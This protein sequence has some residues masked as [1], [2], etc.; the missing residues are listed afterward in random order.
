MN[1]TLSGT[2]IQYRREK[3]ILFEEYKFLVQNN[4]FY[5]NGLIYQLSEYSYGN[6]IRGKYEYLAHEHVF[7]IYMTW[8][9]SSFVCKTDSVWN[10]RIMTKWTSIF[11]TFNEENCISVTSIN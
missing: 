2:S 10:Y 3:N 5:C 4:V 8:T 6:N 7:Y 9:T 11:L 1:R